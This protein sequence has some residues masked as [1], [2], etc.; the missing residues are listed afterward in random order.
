MNSLLCFLSVTAH[1]GND[2]A[3][4]LLQILLLCLG[5][6]LLQVRLNLSSQQTGANVC[7]MGIWRAV[8]FLCSTK[9][10]P[11]ELSSTLV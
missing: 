11:T 4:V 5:K 1:R 6:V 8:P 9:G 3:P 7:L 2:S 10:F